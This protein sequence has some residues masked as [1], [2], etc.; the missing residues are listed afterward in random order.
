MKLIPRDRRRETGFTLIE[1]MVVV[2]VIAILAAIALPSFTGMI[3]R[4][5][6]RGAVETL[7]STMQNARFEATKRNTPIYLSFKTGSSWCYGYG[8]SRN[9]DCSNSSTCLYATSNGTGGDTSLTN[10]SLAWSGAATPYFEPVT[11]SLKQYPANTRLAGTATLSYS[12]VGSVDVRI[13]IMG[14]VLACSTSTGTGF[15]SC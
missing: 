7:V 12:A 6:L 14:R 11:G 15:P 3:E 8:D 10:V 1:L 13:S 4:F 5:R 9:C 2:A